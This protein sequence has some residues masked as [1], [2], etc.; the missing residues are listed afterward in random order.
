[1]AFSRDLL[2]LGA[3]SNVLQ[4]IIGEQQIPVRLHF[5]GCGNSDDL[6][7]S[8]FARDD[9][10]YKAFVEKVA[11]RKSEIESKCSRRLR[12]QLTILRDFL[13]GRTLTFRVSLLLVVTFHFLDA[14]T[15]EDRITYG[16]PG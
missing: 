5:L 7:S 6:Q 2:L 1:M 8:Y 16:A 4:T 10:V 11:R 14:P 15:E 12:W 9:R 3:W 13:D